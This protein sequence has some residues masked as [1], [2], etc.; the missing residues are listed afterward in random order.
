M[1]PWAT[2]VLHNRVVEHGLDAYRGKPT[3][4]LGIDSAEG[5]RMARLRPAE[6]RRIAQRLNDL[7][8]HCEQLEREA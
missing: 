7:A 8:F 4:T 5:R 1:S 2:P 3:V 6:A